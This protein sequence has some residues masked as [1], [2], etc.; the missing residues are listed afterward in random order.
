MADIV[1]RDRNGN[2]VEYPGVESI[3]LNTVGGG[4]KEF[5]DPDTV[6]QAVEKT[7][8]PDFSDGDMEVIPEDGQVFSKVGI[9]KPNNLMPGNIAEGVDIAG[10]IGTLAAGSSARFACGNP[11][12]MSRTITHNLGVMPDLVIAFITPGSGATRT[13]DYIAVYMSDVLKNAI[14]A[15]F[16]AFRA[17]CATTGTTFTSKTT[18]PLSCTTTEITFDISVKI[19]KPYYWIAIGGLT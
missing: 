17:G 6:P 13:E 8:D 7:I 12:V 14:G 9:S 3:K 15:S 1:L 11:T 4:T 16:N 19:S 18:T 5:I 10:I 2:Q